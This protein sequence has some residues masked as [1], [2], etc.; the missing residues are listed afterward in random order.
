MG[1][2]CCWVLPV[3][4]PEG[5]FTNLQ[6]EL[7]TLIQDQPILDS[8][9]QKRWFTRSCW[10]V[11]CAASNS[12][13]QVEFILMC[14]F[15]ILKGV[16]STHV[17]LSV[18]VPPPNVV[19]RAGIRNTILLP[20]QPSINLSICPSVHSFTYAVRTITRKKKAMYVLVCH[21]SRCKKVHF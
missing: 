2:G 12:R 15:I 6:Q 11:P 19:R 17:P 14:F 7:S 13:V 10:N 21:A 18:F 4:R 3:F 9:S 8:V 5:C 1:C 20:I 16:T